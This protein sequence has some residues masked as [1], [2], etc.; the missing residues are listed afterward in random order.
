MSG[1]NIGIS[2][3]PAPA[4]ASLQML[5]DA[6]RRAGQEG[7]NLRD[8]DLS[9]P[10][11]AGFTQDLGRMQQQLEDLVRVSS[12]ATARAARRVLGP[13]PDPL[14]LGSDAEWERHYPDAAERRRLRSN[15]ESY[16][17]RGT[18][19]APAPPPPPPSSAPG[20]PSSTGQGGGIRSRAWGPS[21]YS[22]EAQDAAEALPSSVTIAG[23]TVPIPLRSI[24]KTAANAATFGLSLAGINGIRSTIATGYHQALGENSETDKL[25]RS[26]GTLEDGFGD[27]RESVRKASEGL[28][29]TH[30]EALRMERSYARITGDNTSYGRS[31]SV[32]DNHLKIAAGLAM[33]WGTDVMSAN[34]LV[35][36]AG[37]L[38]MS[39]QE[40]ASLASE[41]AVRAGQS[42]NFEGIEQAILRYM[43]TTSRF[44]ITAPGNPN[45]F[46]SL[47]AGMNATG[48]PGLKGQNAEALITSI[49]ST[50]RGGGGG[51][52]AGQ[53]AMFRAFSRHGVKDAY[54]MTRLQQRGMFAELPDGSTLYDAILDEVNRETHGLGEGAKDMALSTMIGTTMDGASALRKNV[55]SADVTRIGKFLTQNGLK[56]VDPTSYADLA[57][58]LDG[59]GSLPS[60]RDEW[61]KRHSGDAKDKLST[62]ETDLLNDAKGDDLRNKLALSIARHGT[63]R[64][65]QNETTQAGVDLSNKLTE[66]GQ[67]AVGFVNALKQGTTAIMDAFSTLGKFF[68]EG[69]QPGT[70]AHPL[71]G[72]PDANGVIQSAFHPGNVNLPKPSGTAPNKPT[73]TPG[74]LGPVLDLIGEAEGTDRGRGYNETLGFGRYTGGNQDLTKMTLDQ[75]DGLQSRMLANPANS[76]HSSALGRYQIIRTT[77]RRLRERYGLKGD[78]VFD[79]KMQ[80]ELASRL[81]EEGG[82]SQETLSHEWASI[83]DP[84]TGHSHY[85]QHTGTT[86][87]RVRSAIDAAKKRSSQQHSVEVSASIAPLQVIHQDQRGN[88]LREEWLQVT[89]LGQPM[90]WGQA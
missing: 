49:D 11:L 45:A 62:D 8:I 31:V 84:T 74:Q 79:Q 67:A 17:T 78:Q 35:A 46:G 5:Q 47:L 75:I 26:L 64:N 16:V 68:S 12:G 42:G 88:P 53:A 38:G 7:R 24:A 14:D 23:T 34:N 83:P 85:G 44:M 56:D 73:L 71:F 36:R 25:L 81:I 37:N 29:V 6:F 4:I 19:F 32:D 60:M 90:A 63:T 61:I 30:E 72:S 89:P 54:E 57:K 28:Q 33:G 52:M 51:G 82:L 66:A 1:V 70:G 41:T 43:E 65:V 9:H 39:P 86:S 80:D 58:V 18:G 55:K 15:V 59:T 77:L 48:L 21:Y 69:P 22:N 50:I 10:E 27:L 2:A 87:A 3:N 76:L 13:T 40:I 20:P